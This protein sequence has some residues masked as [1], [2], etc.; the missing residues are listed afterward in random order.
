MQASKMVPLLI[1]TFL[2][3]SSLLYPTVAQLPKNSCLGCHANEAL[4]KP[5]VKE[6]V[7]SKDYG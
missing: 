5:L 3:L 4:L 2:F 7:A 6:A 1:V